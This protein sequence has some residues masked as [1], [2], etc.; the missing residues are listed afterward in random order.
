MNDLTQEVVRELFSLDE[1]TGTLYWKTSPRARVQ[2][3]SVAGCPAKNG[4]WVIYVKGKQRLRSRLVF[5]YMHGWLPEEVDHR[6]LDK[7]NDRPGNLRAATRSQNAANRK[8][9]KR[10][11]FHLPKG[12]K[13]NPKGSKNPFIAVVTLPG[14]GSRN[15]G[16]FPTAEAAHAAH[17]TVTHERYG[18]FS[19]YE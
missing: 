6:D 2:V 13:P 15:L 19:S 5:L 10:K 12:V 4:R 14:K 18:E 7:S 9:G 17:C 16:Y 8:T 3:G 1:T 11:H